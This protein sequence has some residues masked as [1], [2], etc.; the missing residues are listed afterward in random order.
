MGFLRV[1]R[2][3]VDVIVKFPSAFSPQNIYRNHSRRENT[4]ERIEKETLLALCCFVVL[5]NNNLCCSNFEI[6]PPTV[7]MLTLGACQTVQVSSSKANF[8]AI[9]CIVSVGCHFEK[10]LI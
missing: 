10:N 8:K 6:K 7:E 5:Q 1:Y 3:I 4:E 9:F 2:F